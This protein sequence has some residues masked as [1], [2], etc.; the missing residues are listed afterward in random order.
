MNMTN[1]GI[2][3]ENLVGGRKS[4]SSTMSGPGI[5]ITI[6]WEKMPKRRFETQHLNNFRM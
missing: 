3:C 4:M 2:E 6:E 1:I 5:N